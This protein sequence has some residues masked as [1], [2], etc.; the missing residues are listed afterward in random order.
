MSDELDL[1]NGHL[2]TLEDVELKPTLKVI[3]GEYYQRQSLL[4]RELLRPFVFTLPHCRCLHV[5]A[6]SRPDGK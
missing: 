6:V 5:S 2:P 1:T 3:Y 4:L